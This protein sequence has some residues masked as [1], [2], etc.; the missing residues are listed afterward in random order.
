VKTLKDLILYKLAEELKA[1]DITAEDIYN[2]DI[3]NTDG[4][5]FEIRLKEPMETVNIE[6]EITE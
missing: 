1:R 6:I 4:M 5:A 2:I 3:I